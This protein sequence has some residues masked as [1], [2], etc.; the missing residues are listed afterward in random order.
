MSP[1][2]RP[3][4]GCGVQTVTSDRDND[5]DRDD[6]RVCVPGGQVRGQRLVA[7]ETVGED[8]GHRGQHA[9]ANQRQHQ[10]QRADQCRDPAPGDD[11]EVRAHEQGCDRQEGGRRGPRTPENGAQRD[12]HQRGHESIEDG[13]LNVAFNGDMPGTG[14][15]DGKLVGLDGELMQMVAEK[16]GLKVNF[17]KKPESIPEEL[18]I[19]F[20]EI[21]DLKSA[22]EALTPGRQRGYLLYFSG[23]KQAKTREAR[24]EKYRQKILNGKGVND[25]ERR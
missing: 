4:V 17:K 9:E 11:A 12:E 25:R 10:H 3:P 24:V 5:S 13:T 21:P 16:I 6:G 14:F 19:K 1:G 20:D 18:R 15:Q 23:A 7:R 8:A 22:F 2:A